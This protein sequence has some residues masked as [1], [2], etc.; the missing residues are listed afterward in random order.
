MDYQAISTI[1]RQFLADQW[2]Q[3][4][5]SVQISGLRGFDGQTIAF[6]FPVVAIVGENGAGKS[7]V[8]KT[9]ASAYEGL[10]SSRTYYPSTFFV[11]THWDTVENIDLKFRVRQGPNRLDYSI[12]KPTKRWSFPGGRPKRN[13]HIFDISRTLPLDASVGYARIARLALG[14]VAS[15]VISDEFRAPL[16]HILGKDYS[17][18]RF[19]KPDVDQTRE[20][21]LLRS[22]VG[23][24]SQ[25][26]QG[27][28]EDATLDLF[29][30]IQVI[31]DYSLLIIDEVEASLHPRAQR[32]LVRFLLK[33]SR[34]KRLQ[35][36]LSTHSPYVLQELPPEARILLIKGLQGIE[37]VSGVTPEL[38]LS[39]I[40]EE[41]HPEL[42]LFVEDREAQILLREIILRHPL[43]PSALSRSAIIEAG[44][45]NVVR[46]LGSLAAKNRFPIRALG[47][48]DGDQSPSD[49]CVVI[50]GGA[51]PER[52]VY[53]GL[54]DAQWPHLV[55]RFGVPAG[56]LYTYLEDAL[57][58]P[59]H[60][61][62]NSLVGSRLLR[63]AS[64]VWELL[65]TEWCATCLQD[66]DR[67]AIAES[68]V[69]HLP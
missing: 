16:S 57:R 63:S 35:I 27:A 64:S 65:A 32:R 26:H 25:F 46:D 8:L 58:E 41:A 15:E 7:T 14:D 37:A 55:E 49:G 51:A 54:R 13:V 21:G 62:W 48:L 9:A 33:L 29:R 59:N 38:A 45:V 20:V 17:S 24:I 1:R 60:H 19:V 18:A 5:E 11:A 52:V 6:Q 23:E 68:V 40:D 22:E 66:A 2:P 42:Y 50:P 31:P 12:R 3:F 69:A 44:A 36:I 30:I 67:N 28:G 61:K 56:D 10:D 47:V 39:R 34:T 43:G 53:E 4:L